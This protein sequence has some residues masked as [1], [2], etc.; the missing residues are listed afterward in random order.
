MT[1]EQKKELRK[2][3]SIIIISTSIMILGLLTVIV[4]LKRGTVSWIGIIVMAAMILNLIPSIKQK[5]AFNEEISKS[6][7]NSDNL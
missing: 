4:G 1:E 7:D 5:K 2:I 6:S 3:N